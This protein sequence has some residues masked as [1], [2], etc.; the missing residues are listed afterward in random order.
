MALL[1]EKDAFQERVCFD[2]KL[3]FCHIDF[4]VVFAGEENPLFVADS[5]PLCDGRGSCLFFTGMKN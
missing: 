1:E 5:Y 3:D 2:G 4:V